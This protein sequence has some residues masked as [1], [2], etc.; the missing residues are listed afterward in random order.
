MLIDDVNSYIITP[1]PFKLVKL[2]RTF[3]KQLFNYASLDIHYAIVKNP[4]SDYC[5]LKYFDIS[6]TV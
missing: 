2:E 6:A 3:V 4:D 5:D 1:A